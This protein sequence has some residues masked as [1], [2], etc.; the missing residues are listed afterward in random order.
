MNRNE[1]RKFKRKFDKVFD[2]VSRNGPN[3]DDFLSDESSCTTHSN[4]SSEEIQCVNDD[5]KNV[6]N[7]S[8]LNLHENSSCPEIAKINSDSL[9]N[10]L[11]VTEDIEGSLPMN[12]SEIMK[13]GLLD[14]PSGKQEFL[15]A[16]RN[17]AV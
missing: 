2:C 8:H 6:T 14:L 17:W 12:I 4:S 3:V 10:D 7:S 5:V 16:L 9:S 11:F 15:Y 1:R 13:A